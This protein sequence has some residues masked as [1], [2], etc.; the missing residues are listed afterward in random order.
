M[1]ADQHAIFFRSFA[2]MTQ[3]MDEADTNGTPLLQMFEPRS[4]DREQPRAVI[5]SSSAS[6]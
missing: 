1:P 4:E 3:M 5:K 2:A 6:A